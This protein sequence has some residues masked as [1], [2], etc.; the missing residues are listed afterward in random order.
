M[1]A[2]QLVE[3]PSDKKPSEAL[4]A[5]QSGYK[6]PPNG[7]IWSPEIPLRTARIFAGPGSR[8]TSAARI[9]LNMAFSGQDGRGMSS[10]RRIIACIHLDLYV[11][12][13]FVYADGSQTMFGRGG[14]QIPDGLAE[15]VFD[16]A[17]DLG[18]RIE[19]VKVMEADD[20][21]TIGSIEVRRFFPS[22]RSISLRL[23]LFLFH[24]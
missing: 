14:S 11:G 5:Y 24:S 6:W 17:G 16:I 18:E 12:I 22:L 1:V 2:I 13:C 8:S 4:I 15:S 9:H 19:V 23:M 21:H 10:L 20:Y 7:W 3:Q